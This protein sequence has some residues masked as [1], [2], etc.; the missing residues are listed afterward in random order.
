MT[1][2]VELR[3]YQVE[4]VEAMAKHTRGICVAPAG[5]GKTIIAA[6]LAHDRA[7]MAQC[8]VPG[9]VP[10]LAWIAH[11]KE[12]VGQA[13]EAL[14]AAGVPD[15]A[16]CRVSCYAAHNERLSVADILIV[17]ECHWAGC[18]QVRSLVQAAKPGAWIYGFTATPTRADGVDIAE[19]IGPVLYTVDRSCMIEAG[20][21]V[22]AEVRVV[23]TGT[24][25]EQEIEALA[26]TYYTNGQRWH[27]K[28]TGT[29]DQWKRCIYRAAVN[30][31]V[32]GNE[33]RDRIIINEAC[34]NMD[35]GES[36]LIIVDTKE[37]GG[38]LAAE[39]PCAQFVASGSKWRKSAIGGFRSGAVPVL[40]ATALADEG[41]DVPRASVLIMASS[42][43][44]ARQV[45][46]RTGRV[47][48]PSDGKDKGIIYDFLD[49]G[50]GML[51]AQ[52]WQRRRE[53]KR[54]GYTVRKWGDA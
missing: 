51:E 40:V 28:Q 35:A 39:T 15:V 16:S 27:D 22:P 20:A 3:P 53:Y 10:V 31:C 12:Q 48:R 19:I 34:L 29:D 45:I 37:H 47:L 50:H 7:G 24:N 1:G 42:G 2:R 41:L 32:R 14:W 44:S 25:I 6:A 54:L 17:D 4:A 33:A 8:T 46:Q 21:V 23:E 26:E 38:K 5:S 11:T 9:Q 30:L 43:K 52:H 18:E 36:V 13:L 49:H